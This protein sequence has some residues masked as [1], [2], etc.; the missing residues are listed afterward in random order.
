M[1]RRPSTRGAMAIQLTHR[2]HGLEG[3]R[4]G[5]PGLYCNLCVPCGC[6]SLFYGLNRKYH[7]Q[8]LRRRAALGFGGAFLNSLTIMNSQHISRR[9]LLRNLG[10]ITLALGAGTTAGARVVKKLGRAR[11]DC[12]GGL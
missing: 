8:G 11:N 7:C 2:L 3:A 10:G 4:G 12:N 9:E 6:R 5:L 1:L